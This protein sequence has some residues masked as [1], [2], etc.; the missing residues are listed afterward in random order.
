MKNLNEFSEEIEF[1]EGLVTCGYIDGF[2]NAE[3]SGRLDR[4][5]ITLKKKGMVNE[6]SSRRT[7]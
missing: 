4:I 2:L 7:K 3:E 5:I 6:N 1:L